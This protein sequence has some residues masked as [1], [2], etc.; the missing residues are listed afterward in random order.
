MATAE[1]AF[2]PDW[3]ARQRWFRAKRRPLARVEVLDRAALTDAAQLL[4]LAARYADGGVDAYLVP[5]VVDGGGPREPRDGE[6]VWRALLRSIAQRETLAGESGHFELAATDAL[7]EL[8]PSP[9]L[10][11][12]ALDE[13]RLRVEQSNTSIVLGERLI[14]KLYR[15]LEPGINPDVEVSAF[16]TSVG[17]AGTPALAGSGR[18]LPRDGQPRDAVML[19]AYV[20]SR[21]D[22]WEHMLGC[23][24]A[25]PASGVDAASRIGTVTGELHAALASRPATPGFPAREATDDELVA[26]RASAERQ[27]E[28][29]IAAADGRL[30][31]IADAVRRRLDGIGSASASRVSRIHGDYHLGQLL[32]T[33]DGEFC[34]VDFEGEP[35]RPL[36]ERR[37]VASPLRDVAGMLRSLDYAARTA[38]RDAGRIGL[39]PDAWLAQARGAFLGAYGAIGPADEALLAAF[40][41]EK[42]CYEVRYEANNRPDW[43]WLPVEALERLVAT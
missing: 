7:A 1:V 21:G 36:D 32:V 39:E 37:G 22:G 28:L 31:D 2:A 42:A 24:A 20:A 33:G 38:G 17:F 12:A 35:A 11:A 25:D 27:L 8:L 43:L 5:A 26:W 18:Y 30:D 23:L 29:A 16:L 19:Q 3:L 10:A 15:L 9:A 4:V 40:E 14:L 13:R 6:G 41:V 34:V